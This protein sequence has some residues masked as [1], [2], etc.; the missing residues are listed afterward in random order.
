M[1]DA[2]SLSPDLKRKVD[3]VR[4]QR[5]ALEAAKENAPT[6]RA[7]LDVSA[8]SLLEVERSGEEIEARARA[9]ARAGR[10]RRGRRYGAGADGLQSQSRCRALGR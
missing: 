10:G 6:I 3:Q 2:Q 9:R 7:K 8:A 1:T 5:A 4:A